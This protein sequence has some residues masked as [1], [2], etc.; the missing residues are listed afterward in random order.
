MNYLEKRKMIVWFIFI[1]LSVGYLLATFPIMY[2]SLN[3]WHNYYWSDKYRSEVVPI[4]FTIPLWWITPPMFLF[5]LIKVRF[6]E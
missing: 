4:Y 5:A 3:Y 1:F 6:E 2:Q